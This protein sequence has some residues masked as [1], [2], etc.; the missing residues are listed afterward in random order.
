[1]S[2]RNLPWTLGK[3]FFQM[4]VLRKVTL[5]VIS[6]LALTQEVKCYYN[7]ATTNLREENIDKPKQLT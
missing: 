4:K 5:K 3:W 2:K 6:T 7:N 1:V